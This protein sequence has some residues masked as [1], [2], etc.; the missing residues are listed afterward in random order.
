MPKMPGWGAVGEDELLEFLWTKV[1]QK[2]YIYIRRIYIYFFFIDNMV[3]KIPISRK[4]V[5]DKT[6]KSIF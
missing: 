2:I 4:I 6:C 5:W 1:I 3:I